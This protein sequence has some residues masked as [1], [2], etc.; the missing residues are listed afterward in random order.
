MLA[1]LDL[2]VGVDGPGPGENGDLDPDLLEFG[3]PDRPEP[4]VL[5]GRGDRPLDDGLAK[6][7]CREDVPDAPPELGEVG[8]GLN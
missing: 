6:G 2:L 5:R 1:D 3:D 8:L 7:A 4:R